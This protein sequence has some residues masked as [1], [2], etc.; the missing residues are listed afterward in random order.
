MFADWEVIISL[1]I[2]YPIHKLGWVIAARLALQHTYYSAELMYEDLATQ[3]L[4]SHFS[5][6][7]PSM[8]IYGVDLV[9]RTERRQF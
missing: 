4:V 7:M 8:H 2:E 1:L 5:L 6:L 9:E 3:L